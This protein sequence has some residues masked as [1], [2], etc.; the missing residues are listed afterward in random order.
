VLALPDRCSRSLRLE[1]IA[2][3]ADSVQNSWSVRLEFASQPA[4]VHL[5]Q[6]GIV[7]VITPYRVQDLGG[8]DDP[9]TLRDQEIQQP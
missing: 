4:D 3:A 8:A 1:A 7:G 6:V 9:A 2:D 5:H